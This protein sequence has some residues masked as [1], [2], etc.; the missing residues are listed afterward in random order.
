M[1]TLS[2]PTPPASAGTSQASPSSNQRP[3]H[4]QCKTEPSPAEGIP[5]LPS[6]LHQPQWYSFP[7][8]TFSRKK[9]LHRS[10]Q[11][12]WFQ[13]WEWLHYEEAANVVRCFTCCRAVK[14]GVVKAEGQADGSFLARGLSN[15]KDARSKFRKHEQ[16]DFHKVCVEA[17]SA[18]VDVGDMLNREAAAQKLANREYLLKILSSIRFLARQ[19]LPLRGAGDEADS[20]IQLLLLL[21][22]DYLSI[23]ATWARKN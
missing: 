1:S 20:N 7:Q 6:K 21:G 22:E 4:D 13:E 8:R 2:D 14:S 3:C 9:P 19:A 10:F 5:D 12:S 15:W 11:Q 17:L 16:C 23:L 18:K